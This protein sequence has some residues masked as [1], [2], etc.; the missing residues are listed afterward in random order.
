MES[1]THPKHYNQGN[2]EVIEFIED[3]KLS[4]HSGQVIKYLCRA[5]KKTSDPLEDA[6]KAKWYLDRLI[7]VVNADREGRK[8]IRPNDM[9]PRKK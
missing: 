6:M 3:Q 1:V 9:N 4:Y 2:I 7:E 5:G 8:A